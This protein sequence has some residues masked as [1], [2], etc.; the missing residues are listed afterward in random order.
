MPVP[1]Q[2]SAIIGRSEIRTHA[3]SCIP[4]PAGLPGAG[5]AR[6]SSPL[7]SEAP[8][9]FSSGCFLFCLSV[10]SCERWHFCGQSDVGRLDSGRIPCR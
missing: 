9:I 4:R 1:A 7:V 3:R 5:L 6:S 2:V 10:I 8:V